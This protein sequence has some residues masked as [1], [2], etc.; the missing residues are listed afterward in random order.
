M[1]SRS[2]PPRTGFAS[3]LNFLKEQPEQ[4]FERHGRALSDLTPEK[5]DQ[6]R[7][8]LAE[9]PADKK[10]AFFRG[11]WNDALENPV[12]SYVSIAKLG[13]GDADAGIRTVSIKTLGLEDSREIG[14]LMLEKAIS[15]PHEAPR[16]AAIE[17]LG[18]YMFDDHL[19]M[20]IPVSRK[21]LRETL[22]SLIENS[23]AAI[24]RAA[25]A[26]YAIS[27]DKRVKE[28]ISGYF[29]GNDPEELRTA[30]LAV[31]LS[32]M[33]DWN[34]TVLELLSHEDDAVRMDAFR[35][36]G[37]L[38]LREALP[39]LYEVIANFD[40]VPS[41][42]LIAA[43]NA[44]AEI[45]DEGSLDVL[46]TLGEAAV[47]QDDEVTEAIDDAID[48]LSMTMNLDEEPEF[49]LWESRKLSPK[50]EAALLDRL[51]RAKD[52][53]LSILEEKI[54]MDTE[55]D[56]DDHDHEHDEDCDCGEHHHHHH[57]HDHE[58]LDLS[59]FRIVDDLEAYEKAADRD[60]D[61]EALWA[62]FEALDE[63]D[64]DADSLRDFMEKLERKRRPSSGRR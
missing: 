3:A 25:V 23:S 45:G 32:L 20:P 51:E 47:D 54:P 35:T 2:N 28:I 52:K 10:A 13:A 26:A 42:L 9:L 57:H 60:E 21:K 18:Q 36:A 38:E 19:S 24:R 5:L 49:D 59:R 1:A 44:V 43:V 15:D 27:E 39:V 41:D 14:A 50:K 63:E 17:N 29:A 30:L 22:A 6:L 56:E 11:M 4:V 33:E 16:V 8:V 62:E 48:V 46:E 34:G 31:H 37:S 7:A 40:R 64:L 53:C 55:D 61:E 58:H 12:N